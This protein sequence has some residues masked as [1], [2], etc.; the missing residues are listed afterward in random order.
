ML[1]RSTVETVCLLSN[2]KCASSEPKPELAQGLGERRDSERSLLDFVN[3]KPDAHVDLSQDMEDY[4]YE[5]GSY[6]LS[7]ATMTYAGYRS[8]SSYPQYR[9]KCVV[10][11][12]YVYIPS[13]DAAG[14]YKINISNSADVELIE[15]GFTSGAKSLNESSYGLFLTRI[16]DLIIGYDFQITADDTVIQTVGSARFDY[17]GTPMFQYKN[18]VIFWGGEY[19]TERR[20]VAILTPYLA[21]I[22]N[23]DSAVVKTSDMTMKIT[24]T[25]TETE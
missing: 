24:Y 23:L 16:E 20:I 6:T 22:C 15:L 4:T 17:T 2:R 18:F 7:N 1:R 11:D 3:L 25:L 19:S 5:E 13:Y 10:R 12:G 14:V 9:N 21:T 8:F